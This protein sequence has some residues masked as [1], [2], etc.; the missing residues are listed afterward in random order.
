MDKSDLIQDDFLELLGENIIKYKPTVTT[1]HVVKSDL[2]NGACEK[3]RNA[4]LDKDESTNDALLQNSEDS[5]TIDSSHLP[6]EISD[7]DDEQIYE[8]RFHLT[9]L[10]IFHQKTEI[11]IDSTKME[12]EN[13]EKQNQENRVEES[14][15]VENFELDKGHDY[16]IYIFKSRYNF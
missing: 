1:N 13:A 12:N 4:H 2:D 8:K 7:S 6:G 15:L 11:E 10:D 16:N 9:K 14:S 5:K 3:L